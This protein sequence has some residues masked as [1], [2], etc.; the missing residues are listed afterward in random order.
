[1]LINLAVAESLANSLFRFPAMTPSIDLQPFRDELEQLYLADGYTHEQLVQWLAGQGLVVASR[2]LKKRFKD[3]GITRRQ[4]ALTPAALETISHLFHT[5]TDDDNAI[6]RALTAQG[7]AVSAGQ[8]QQTRLTHGWR[9]RNNDPE[10]REE[11]RQ[12]TG[13]AVTELLTDSGRNYGRNYL[14]TALRLQGHRARKDDV[15]AELRRQDPNG[16][17]HR[18]PGKGQRHRR[19]EF[20]NPGPDHLW[21]I[22]GHDK[23]KAWGIEIYAAIDAYSRKIIWTYVGNANRSRLAVA[24][25]YLETVAQSN[26][27]PRF[28]RADKGQEAVL[29]ADAHLRLFLDYR[30]LAG[31]DQSTLDSL[32]VNECF[33]FGPS[34]ANQRIE[35][36]W[37]RL[38]TTQLEWWITY[39]RYLEINGF[40]VSGQISDTAVLLF[41]FMPILR[42]EVNAFVQMWNDHPIRKQR[43]LANH[44]PGVP[45]KL[46][47]HR[48]DG[49]RLGFQPN[50]DLVNDLLHS[51]DGFDYDAYLT[52]DT[53]AWLQQQ[54]DQIFN[55]L[56]ITTGIA[57]SDFRHNG[58]PIVPEYYRTLVTRARQHPEFLRLAPKPEPEDGLGWQELHV[59]QLSVDAMVNDISTGAGPALVE[60]EFAVDAMVTGAGQALVGEE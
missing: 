43:Q 44:I 60:E 5:T 24:R 19:A 22:D 8:V 58:Q 39:F 26:W 35:N 23:I 34:S 17:T 10:Q 29:L 32:P 27:C 59:A 41:V 51:T 30:Q 1:M 28:I 13:L 14:T 7:I 12:Q 9:R 31:D 25:Q 6:A 18:Q 47:D 45:N 20:I 56:G 37:C 53:M 21:C 3:W 4:A 54:L 49:E 55:Q 52:D 40:F 42:R 48:P 16:T 46:Y 33:W 11:Q 36:W 2:T 57:S 50:A 38:R 15:E